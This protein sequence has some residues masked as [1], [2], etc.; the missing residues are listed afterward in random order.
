MDEFGSPRL[1]GACVYHSA[2]MSGA[3]A[4]AGCLLAAGFDTIDHAASS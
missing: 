1:R 2:K 3:V 4:G